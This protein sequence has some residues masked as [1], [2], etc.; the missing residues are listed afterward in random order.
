VA[1]KIR[2]ELWVFTR[3]VFSIPRILRIK[4]KIHKEKQKKTNQTR[5]VSQ[6]DKVSK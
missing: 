1:K 3:Y 6:K 2:T 4:F 5:I